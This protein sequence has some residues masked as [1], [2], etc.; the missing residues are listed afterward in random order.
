MEDL[1]FEIRQAILYKERGGG[2]STDVLGIFEGVSVRGCDFNKV[3]KQLCL[4]CA[5]ALLFSCGL[6]HVCRACLEGCF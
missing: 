2:C 5:S 6:L 1:L 4:G 3:A